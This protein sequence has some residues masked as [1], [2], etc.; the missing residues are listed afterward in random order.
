MGLLPN[1][2]KKD[3]DPQDPP[4]PV[5]PEIT[6]IGND[7][8]D[9]DGAEHVDP[10][11]PEDGYTAPPSGATNDKGEK[12]KGKGRS[13]KSSSMTRDPSNHSHSSHRSENSEHSR[14]SRYSRRDGNG[15]RRTRTGPPPGDDGPDSSESF[16]SISR[17]SSYNDRH[18]SGVK[19]VH[20]LIDHNKHVKACYNDSLGR[21][22]VEMFIQIQGNDGHLDYDKRKTIIDSFVG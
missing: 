15:Q 13:S 21:S 14:K 8:Q 5:E 7:P 9:H 12:N 17:D 20:W 11:H 2:N 22:H 19:D 4:H 10:P 6:V 1:Q 3:K 16:S 18:G